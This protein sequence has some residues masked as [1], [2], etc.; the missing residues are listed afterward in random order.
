[1][2][3]LADHREDLVVINLKI[4]LLRPTWR[5]VDTPTLIHRVDTLNEMI[6]IPER[7]KLIILAVEIPR[8]LIILNR[9]EL[10]VVKITEIRLHIT[11]KNTQELRKAITIVQ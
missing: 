9:M 2:M 11:D 8:R 1:M 7:S 4:L 6:M 3:S 5:E 10:G